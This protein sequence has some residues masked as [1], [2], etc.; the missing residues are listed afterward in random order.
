MTMLGTTDPVDWPSV[1]ADL[2]RGFGRGL[3]HYDGSRLAQAALM[4]L[5]VFDQAQAQRTSQRP[6]SNKDDHEQ[7]ASMLLW[8][9]MT[10]AELAAFQR[11]SPEQQSAI[12][13]EA[14]E[15][16]LSADLPDHGYRSLPNHSGHSRRSPGLGI[17][18]D[19]YRQRP[20][21]PSPFA[22]WPLEAILP[23]TRDGRLNIPT[24]RR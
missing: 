10:A 1:W 16:G 5:D 20:L 11:S 21:S 4:G 24:L 14:E 2:L 23:F 8:P 17:V 13:Q 3:L 18:P 19:P 6:E 12:S 7:Y 9:G 15:A 22:G